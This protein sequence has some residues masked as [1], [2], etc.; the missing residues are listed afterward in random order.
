[1]KLNDG[2]YELNESKLVLLKSRLELLDLVLPNDVKPEY[3]PKPSVSFTADCYL[4]AGLEATTGS[5]EGF[6]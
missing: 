3:D 4:G 2:L 6:S 1:M 5:Y